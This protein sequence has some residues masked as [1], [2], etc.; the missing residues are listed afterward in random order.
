[1]KRFPA[2]LWIIALCAGLLIYCILDAPAEPMPQPSTEATTE[3]TAEPTTEPAT[4]PSTQPTTEPTTEPTT[5]P[6]TEP[7]TEPVTEPSTEAPSEPVTPAQVRI[8][9]TD[10]ALRDA[11]AAL[12]AD[13]T[14]KTGIEVVLVTDFN[15]ATL[16][17]LSADLIDPALCA[18][19]SGTMAYAQLTSWDLA[20]GQRDLVYAI[21]AEVDCF[22]LIYNHTLMAQAA[23]TQQDV[24][25][26][27]TLAQ[28]AGNLAQAGLTPFAGLEFNGPF[29]ARLASIPGDLRPLLDLWIA[30]CSPQP[31]ESALAQFIDAQAVFYLGSTGEYEAVSAIGALNLGILPVYLGD[32]EENQSLCLAAKRYWCV[33][34]QAPAQDIQATLD[35]LSALVVSDGQS[36]PPVD[37]LSLLSPYRQATYAANPLEQILRE[38]VRS[39]KTVVVCDYLTVPPTGLPEALTAYAADPNEENWTAILAI[40]AE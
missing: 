36:A 9:A 15:E 1:M 25:N 21:A 30:H 22:G 37:R 11:W 12:A 29:A 7:T 31:P 38:D 24:K 2:I 20:L 13:Y 16:R 28:T 17:T 33:S 18:D 6:T 26:L 14:A 5:A 27:S 35:F 3:P 19:L 39:G 4:E 40:L 34:N 32:K 23:H 10:P 8:L